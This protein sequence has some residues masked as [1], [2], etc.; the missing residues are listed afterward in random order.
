MS[1]MKL[2]IRRSGTF[3]VTWSGSNAS[4]CGALGTQ[5]LTY[6]VVIVGHEQHLTPEGF[7]I[8]NNDIHQYFVRTYQNVGDFES[9]ERIAARACRDFRQM[10]GKGALADVKVSRIEVTIS[11]SPTAGLTAEWEAPAE[12][13]ASKVRVNHVGDDLR[14]EAERAR[15]RKAV[16][17]QRGGFVGMKLGS[18][19]QG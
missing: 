12:R 13:A 15:P 19:P 7:I 6:A 2:T 3:A 9:C 16:T 17:E 4:Q 18:A 11:G 1:D 5:V 14:P 8:D 10:F